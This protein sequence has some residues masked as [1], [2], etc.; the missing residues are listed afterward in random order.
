[1][2]TQNV[3]ISVRKDLLKKVKLIAV[4]QNTS[5]SGLVRDYLE[6]LVEEESG[7][8]QAKEF[9]IREMN[10]E[11]KIGAKPGSYTRDELHERN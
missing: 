10:K 2:E 8:Q 3:T 9:C 11:Y 1:M 5:L 6:K 4:E 7:Y